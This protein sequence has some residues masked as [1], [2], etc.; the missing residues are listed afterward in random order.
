[1]RWFWRRR[2]IPEERPPAPAR[3]ELRVRLEP[4]DFSDENII[5]GA[6]LVTP[7]FQRDLSTWRLT[8]RGDGLVCQDIR[9]CIPGT[10]FRGEVR[11]ETTQ[12]PI[13]EVS[14]ILAIADRIGFRN[15][16]G[17]Y[18]SPTVDEETCSI[19]IRFADGVKLVETYG[20][21]DLAVFQNKEEMHGFMELWS[22]IHRY[23]PYPPEP[24]P[25]EMSTREAAL[26]WDKRLKAAGVYYPD[27]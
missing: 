8:I 19:G 26:Y 18:E 7:S 2:S 5:V 12:L 16:Q 22:R 17:H 14:A 20:P 23:S 3:P 15:F 1:M 6:A 21:W 4:V 10:P 11:Q 13:E 27:K 25:E 24:R 9:V